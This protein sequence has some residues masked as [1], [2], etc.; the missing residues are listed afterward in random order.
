[1]GWKGADLQGVCECG[2]GELGDGTD[3]EGVG[4]WDVLDACIQEALPPPA[5]ELLVRHHLD[6]AVR[7]QQ[8]RRAEATVEAGEAVRAQHGA[9]GAG[10]AE[11]G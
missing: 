7:A 2:G 10:E 8:Q 3:D 1:M 6:G 4:V 9:H 5:L 11:G